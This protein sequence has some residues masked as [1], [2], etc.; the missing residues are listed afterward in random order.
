MK[1]IR[2]LSLSLFALFI[3]V[4]T[5]CQVSEKG[6]E[7]SSNN[8]V[9][10]PPLPQQQQQINAPQ[11]LMNVQTRNANVDAII[12]PVVELDTV[13]PPLPPDA[14]NRIQIALLLDTSSS[15]NGLI[16]QAK[17]QLWKMVNELA[18]SSKGNEAPQ[19]EL[20]LYE[21][22]NSRLSANEGYIRK[23][24]RLT[25][26]LEWIS[27]R[28][29]QLTTTGGE[30]YCPWAIKDAIEDL[31]WSENNNDLKIIF[32]A[33]NE[34][35]Q[36]GPV[37]FQE[38]CPL[39]KQKGI[40]VNT[41]HC[42]DYDAGVRDGWSDGAICAKGKYMNI[43]QD[44]KVVHVPTP[45]DEKVLELN[46]QLNET[47]LGYGGK[48]QE[49]KE[50]QTANDVAASGYSSANTRTRAF[51]KSKSNYKNSSWDIVDATEKDYDGF[52][53]DVDKKELPKELRDLSGT[54]LKAFV[55][56]KRAERK[57]LQVELKE[58]EGKVDKYVAEKKQA[59]SEEEGEKNTLDN[60]M[61]KSIR[62]QAKDKSFK[63]E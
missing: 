38:V 21:Y 48:G 15:M 7:T 54:E 49:Y 3:V 60:V 8:P 46:K 29:F 45:Y 11:Q 40:I 19:I 16:D 50:M 34:P 42:G 41:I 10:A 25:T 1:N 58:I 55:E 35:F 9:M 6:S 26:D 33:G 27:V 30:E 12:Q 53:K 39:A 24:G 28:L 17:S 43:N 59:M 44:E 2:F 18:K 61:M 13:Q 51:Y 62:K 52:M 23:I 14:R 4:T 20:A 31:T 22:G 37:P 56:K 63:F 57:Q 36:Q 32:I 47:Y 5:S